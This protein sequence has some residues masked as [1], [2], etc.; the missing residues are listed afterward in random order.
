MLFSSRVFSSLAIY[1]VASW[2][3]VRGIGWVAGRFG[4]SPHLADVAM[5][6]F[7]SLIPTVWILAARSG[8]AHDGTTI[9]SWK[10]LLKFGV[11]LNQATG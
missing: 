4:L 7:L 10:K 9:R 6:A 11:L 8:S 1:F 5:I 2:L 3:L